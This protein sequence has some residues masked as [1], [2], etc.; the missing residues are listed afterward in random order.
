VVC[1]LTAGLACIPCI[2]GIVLSACGVAAL[3]L[4]IVICIARCI[5][6]N[7]NPP[8]TPT[9]PPCPGDCDGDGQVTVGDIL[10]TVNISLG[11]AEI[12]KCETGDANGDGQI[13]VDEIL[14]AMNKALSGCS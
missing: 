7:Y 5:N 14:T 11:N 12:G 3:A 2:T 13:T 8:P 10:T 6:P 4:P 1:G 9:P